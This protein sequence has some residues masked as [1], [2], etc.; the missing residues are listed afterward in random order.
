MSR[1]HSHKRAALVAAVS[2]ISFTAA[3]AALWSAPRLSDA[4]AA[5]LRTPRVH[6]ATLSVPAGLPVQP[7]SHVRAS[8]SSAKASAT[9]TAARDAAVTLDAG[10]RFTMIGV[11]C[12]VPRHADGVLVDLRT[13]LDGVSWSRW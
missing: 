12:A 8:S 10:L 1:S 9:V 4:V 3:L 2:I 7:V 6:A 13:S 11:T 5:W